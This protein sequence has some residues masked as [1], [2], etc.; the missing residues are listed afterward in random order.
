MAIFNHRGHRVTQNSKLLL[1]FS[2]TG[3][4]LRIEK[5]SIHDGDG[6]RTVVFLKGCPLRCAWCS[7]PESQ[8]AA[9]DHGYGLIMTAEE[10]LK[11]ITKDEVFYFHSGGGVTISGGEPLMQSDFTYVLIRECRKMGINTAIETCACGDYSS[12]EKL[13][14]HLDI[15]YADLKL[16]DDAEHI[17]QT[18]VSN[19]TILENI[20]RLSKEFSGKLRIRM[21]L[22]PSINMDD[23][24]IRAAAGFCESLLKHSPSSLDF[25]EFLPYHRLGIDTYRKLG[26]EFLLSSIMP[27]DRES[28]E[29]AKSVFREIAPGVRVI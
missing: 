29:R 13:L 5:G 1:P 8:D 14:P 16:M 6:L 25:V 9:F 2:S 18:G 19:K 27:P 12:M 3:K 10:V 26:R 23:E 4:V 21:P 7:S 24:E 20:R 28:V 17:K 11:E 22:V 15:I